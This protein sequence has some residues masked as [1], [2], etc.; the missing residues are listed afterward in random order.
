MADYVARALELNE[1]NIW[2]TN[3]GTGGDIFE[4]HTLAEKNNLHPKFG[5]EAYIVPNPL[6]KDAENYHLVVIPK[7]NT[8]RKKLNKASSRANIEGFY[9]KPRFFLEDLLNNFSSDE[10]FL[11]TACMG[12]IAKNETAITEILYPLAE[13]FGQNMLLEVQ[14]HNETSQ[15]LHNQKIL[16][17]A[18]DLSLPLIAANDSHYIYTAQTAQ[19]K[20]LQL[21]KNIV[22]A[23]E[24]NFILDY[25]D[26]DTFYRRFREQN[27]LTDSQISQAIEN[28]LMFDI[29]ED[30]Y[31]DHEIKMPSIYRHLTEDEKIAELKHIINVKFPQ[32]MKQD[33]IDKERQ[34][35]YK[36][37]IRK[38]MQVIEDT[39]TLHTADYFLFN[40]RMV[41]LAVDKYGGTLTRSGRGSGGAF[42][43]NKI[44][45][46]TQ[47]DRLDVALP[48]YTE[49]FMSTARLLEN[50]A[51]PDETSSL[52]TV[53]YI[54]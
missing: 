47:I 50:K 37:E 30:I 39:K 2:T 26:I 42:L 45:G 54:E 6:T 53:M 14:P 25:P 33:G 5:I 21:G 9:Y 3:H 41:E 52:Y 15:K 51:S 22:Y 34:K 18:S 43:I 13:K 27:I 35:L 19:R 29:C 49:R 17:L 11:T 44:L 23:D 31:L 1:P 10:L 16:K 8:A 48:I 32:V 38:E 12:G 40:N 28:T 46:I 4:A 20:Q 36:Q 7:T 24:E